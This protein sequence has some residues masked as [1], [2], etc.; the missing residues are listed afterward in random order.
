MVMKS[1]ILGGAI[2]LEQGR[3]TLAGGLTIFWFLKISSL[4]LKMPLY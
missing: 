4:G 2:E 3:K 1:N